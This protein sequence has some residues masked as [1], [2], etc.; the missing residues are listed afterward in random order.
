MHQ[1]LSS[2]IRLLFVENINWDE[3]IWENVFISL[4][5]AETCKVSSWWDLQAVYTQTK[6]NHRSFSWVQ[7]DGLTLEPPPVAVAFSFIRK[8]RLLP[9]RVK[10]VTQKDTFSVLHYY[11]QPVGLTLSRLFKVGPLKDV[12]IRMMLRI[13]YYWRCMKGQ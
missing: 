8:G 9:R 6:C 4:T 7:G 1:L 5:S 11:R 3:K 10:S 13:P 2:M 12:A